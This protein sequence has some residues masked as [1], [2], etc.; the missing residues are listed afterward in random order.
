MPELVELN[1]GH[2]AR[3]HHPFDAKPLSPAEVVS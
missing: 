1:P 2:R 3:C